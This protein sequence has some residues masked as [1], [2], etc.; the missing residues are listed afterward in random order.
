MKIALTKPQA[1]ALIKGKGVQLKHSQLGDG[2]EVPL[3]ADIMKRLER[4]HKKGMGARVRLTDEYIHGSGIFDWIKENVLAPVGNV[5][6]TVLGN[7]AAPLLTSVVQKKLGVGMKKKGGSFRVAGAGSG[8][9]FKPSGRGA[10]RLRDDDS[11]VIAP[12]HPVMMFQP[13]LPAHDM[14]SVMRGRGMVVDPMKMN[15]KSDITLPTYTRGAGAR[16]RK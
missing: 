4:A 8:G 7:V 2:K 11:L 6:K 5:A 13:Q 9:S 10:P 3:P 15:I 16:R 14:S 1:R 12:Q